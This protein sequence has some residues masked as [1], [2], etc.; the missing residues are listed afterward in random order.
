MFYWVLN[1][2]ILFIPIAC[3]VLVIIN[4]RLS[5]C[6]DIQWGGEKKVVAI[7]VALMYTPDP[8]AVTMFY[9]V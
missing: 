2:V 7:Y 3:I 5:Y 4:I 8:L 1:N 6:T 9:L